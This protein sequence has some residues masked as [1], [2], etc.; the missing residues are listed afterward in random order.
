MSEPAIVKLGDAWRAAGVTGEM[1][2]VAD[3]LNRVENPLC[4]HWS[5]HIP[6]E[7]RAIWADLPIEARIAAIIVAEAAEENVVRD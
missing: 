5:I 3:D 7:L 2:V 6:E 1:M 4:G